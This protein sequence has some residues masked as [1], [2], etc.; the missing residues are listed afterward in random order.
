MIQHSD[1]VKIRIN[2]GIYITVSKF[3]LQIIGNQIAFQI[4]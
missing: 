2:I 1:F 4:K 3:N